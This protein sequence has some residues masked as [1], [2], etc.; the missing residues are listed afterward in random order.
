M[1]TVSEVI[2]SKS[3]INY[4][5]STIKITQSRIDKGLIAIPVSLAE[6]FPAHNTTVQVY[7]DDSEVLHT[8]NYSSYTSSTRECRIGGVAEWF[9]ENQI[10]GGDEI[11]VQLIDKENSIY[12]LIPE[13]KFLIKTQALQKSFDDS[14]DEAGASEQ[15]TKLSRWT[16]LD[17]QKVILNEYRRLI[18]TIKVEKRRYI[19][20]PP[21]RTGENVPY[22]LRVLLGN[23]YRGHCQVC[24]FWFL[25][26]D[27]NPYFETHHIDPS[28]GNSP[29]NIVL[30]CANCHRQFEYANV[31]PERNDDGWLIRVFFNDRNYSINQIVLKME[32][33]G[34]FKKLFV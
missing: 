23:I 18:D 29:K 8:K 6:W 4:S 20:R 1:D 17:A 31:R 30:V 11:V 34:F 7:L 15:I 26:Q 27:N 3:N 19:E 12:K 25:K 14:E 21:S 24:D 33:E 5:Y 10:K 13:H 28:L 9:K 16:D 22:N 2:Q 32:F